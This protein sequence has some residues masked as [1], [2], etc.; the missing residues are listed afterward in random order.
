ML[1]TTAVEQ[2]DNKVWDRSKTTPTRVICLR[3]P[4]CCRQL[5]P[6]LIP[7]A[8]LQGRGPTICDLPCAVQR[9][10]LIQHLSSNKASSSVRWCCVKL[11][12]LSLSILACPSAAGRYRQQAY[13]L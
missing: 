12:N 8:G 10:I 5:I 1:R 2:A 4:T 3:S 6:V 11:P 7:S 13:D 9:P